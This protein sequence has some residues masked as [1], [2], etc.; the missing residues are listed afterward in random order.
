LGE[1]RKGGNA[2]YRRGHQVQALWADPSRTSIGGSV[3]KNATMRKIE[4]V[5]VASTLNLVGGE[6][7][8]KEILEGVLKTFYQGKKSNEHRATTDAGKKAITVTIKEWSP[9]PGKTVLSIL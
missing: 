4:I 1:S 8:V 2:L 6:D 7:A 9:D 5:L 3:V